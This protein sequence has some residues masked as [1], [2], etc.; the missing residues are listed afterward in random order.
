MHRPRWRDSD[1]SV[2]ARCPSLNAAAV[3][4][5]VRVQPRMTTMMLETGYD[6]YTRR[7]IYHQPCQPVVASRIA[8]GHKPIPDA[9]DLADGGPPPP[10]GADRARFRVDRAMARRKIGV[11]PSGVAPL[12]LRAGNQPTNTHA[13]VQ[14]AGARARFFRLP[15]PEFV[16]SEH[17]GSS[18]PLVC[19]LVCPRRAASAN[20]CD[21]SHVGEGGSRSYLHGCHVRCGEHHSR[22]VGYNFQTSS[23]AGVSDYFTE[24]GFWYRH[25]DRPRDTAAPNCSR[26]YGRANFPRA[27]ARPSPDRT[28]PSGRRIQHHVRRLFT[29]HDR[30]RI[31][32]TIP[33]VSVSA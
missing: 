5:R 13:L 33:D 19:P 10:A 4:V 26:R 20:P 15:L 16:A 8:L 1:Q 25:R 7:R 12:Q 3:A 17:R 6:R 11:R 27:H 28:A 9:G 22:R 2:E 23:G 29:D 14:L 31:G 30:R 21:G 18:V 32:I 24:P